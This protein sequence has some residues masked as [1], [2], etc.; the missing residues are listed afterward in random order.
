MLL[1]SLSL[2]NYRKFEDVLVE[3]PEGVTGIV[4][5]NG[6]GKSTL[7][8]AIAWVLYGSMGS[9][10]AVDQIR[11]R[12]VDSSEVCR[13]CLEFEFAD[14]SYSVTREMRGKGLVVHAIALVDG[15]IV[16]EGGSAVSEF[17]VKT[18]GMDYRSF[19]TSIFARQKE[20][21]ALSSM[22]PSERRPLIL[23]LL[24]VDNLDR[25][26]GLIRK[27]IRLKSEV[28]SRL[29]EELE[30]SNGLS[31]KDSLK[32]ELAKLKQEI[33]QKKKSL[34][35]QKAIGEALVAQ[36]G[37]WEDTVQRRRR[38]YEGLLKQ[39]ELLEQKKKKL[40]TKKRLES[41]L[42]S[43]DV[44]KSKLKKEIDESTKK[45]VD[46]KSVEET[47][48]KEKSS[49]KS[50]EQSSADLSSKSKELLVRSEQLDLEKR[51]FESRLKRLS[52]LGPE[53][54]CPTCE[55][56]LGDQFETLQKK[57]LSEV[58]EVDSKK[59]S[60]EKSLDAIKKEEIEVK[61][62][63]EVLQKSV[64]ELEKKNTLLQRL[65]GQLQSLKKS[66]SEL[67]KKIEQKKS[68]L[69]E[70]G[71]IR[72]DEKTYE[73]FRLEVQKSYES[74]QQ[75]SKKLQ[76]MQKEETKSGVLVERLRGQR[77]VLD[78]KSS[79][80]KLRIEELKKSA[81]RLDEL[82]SELSSL[83]S[84]EDVMSDFRVHVVS[85]IRPALSEYASELFSLL[86][87]GK[88]GFVELD[89]QYNLVVDDAGEQFSLERFSGGEVDLANLCVRLAISEVLSERS[90]SVFNFIVLDEVFGSQDVFRRQNIID[91]L[92]SFSG[93]FRQIFLITH[94]D[95]LKNQLENIIEVVESDEGSSMVIVQ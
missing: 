29:K 51:R 43:L 68:A 76:S 48:R 70:L 66:F 45:T 57:F 87:E 71:S 55:R 41:E 11:S 52:D 77:K 81:G 69:V 86:T 8:E 73:E 59:K 40:E 19:F 74:W 46:L 25:V 5:L 89:E 80:I 12:G 39:K 37:E 26:V 9:R 64:L 95:E 38:G 53:A 33:A 47:L 94:L 75:S 49:L 79:E 6:A 93:K 54:D 14:Q 36:I 60:L 16:A 61:K 24:G 1:K 3:F 92:S 32:E 18:L 67:E 4:G 62:K 34:S 56:R 72:F 83:C 23:R 10:T 7:F 90:G 30:D 42:E 58:S 21:N 50:V 28:L 44:E 15:S 85:Q 84:L 91:A 2:K 88:Y 27:D 65:D 22:Q 20:L 63:R 31:K 17:I 35:D 78:Q 13:V 82:S